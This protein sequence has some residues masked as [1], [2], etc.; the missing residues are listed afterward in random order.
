MY[1]LHVCVLLCVC[2]GSQ[3]SALL[4]VYVQYNSMYVFYT[5]SEMSSVVVESFFA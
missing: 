2:M 5:C 3:S 4:F 1:V